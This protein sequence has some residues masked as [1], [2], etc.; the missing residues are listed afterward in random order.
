MSGDSESEL[1]ITQA[2]SAEVSVEVTAIE[3]S[4]NN[5]EHFLWEEETRKQLKISIFAP[6]ILAFNR[7]LYR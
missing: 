7:P 1:L 6:G 5:F 4:E 2:V 3:L